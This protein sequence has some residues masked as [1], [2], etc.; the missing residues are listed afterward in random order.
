MQTEAEISAVTTTQGALG[1]PEA[2]RGEEG[3]FLEPSQHLASRP[4]AARRDRTAFCCSKLPV[5][6]GFLQQPRDTDK[7]ASGSCFR[8]RV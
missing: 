2:G 7:K 6:G 4:P 3:P 1:P 5:W 8:P